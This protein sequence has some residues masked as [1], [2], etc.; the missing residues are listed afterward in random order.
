MSE[1]TSLEASRI[2]GQSVAPWVRGALSAGEVAHLCLEQ[3]LVPCYA[4]LSHSVV[5][6]SLRHHGL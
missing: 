4:M 3:G 6:D 2:G 5:S 1:D